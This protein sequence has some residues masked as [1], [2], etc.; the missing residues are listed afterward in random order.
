MKT[1]LLER[2]QTAPLVGDGA[3][4]TYLH[5]LGYDLREGAEKL[6]LTAPDVIRGVHAAYL[7]A[8]AELIETNTFSASRAVLGE[9]SD[10]VIAAAARL[11]VETA[12]GKAWVAGAV[13]P[14][15]LPEEE[16][17]ETLIADC[18]RRH[19]QTLCENGVDA[20][21]LETFDS[22]LDLLPAVREALAVAGKDIPVFANM[23]FDEGFA[24]SGEKAETIACR[25][26]GWG[27]A[28]VGVNCGRGVQTVTRTVDGL[29]AGCG[30]SA[31]VSAFP[32]AGYPER[33]GG[34]T[35]YLATPAYIAREAAG[36]VQK[37]VRIVGGCC[38]TTP[39]T[40]RAIRQAV[41]GIRNIPVSRVKVS[42]STRIVEVVQAET[43]VQADETRSGGFL[44]SIAGVKLPVIA[45]VDPPPHLDTSAMLTAAKELLK[46]G[47]QA[48]SLAE[49][50]LS[51]IRMENFYL[52]QLLRRETG[53]QVI[54]HITG[55]DRNSLGAQ[56]A[57]MAAHVAG[58]EAILAVTGD[59]PQLGGHRRA[60]S[61]YENN[62]VGLIRLLNRLN[63][64]RGLNG[65]D[66]KGRTNFSVGAAFNSAAVNLEAE[67]TRLFRKQEAG[68]R[69]VM[70]QPVFEYDTACRVLDAV[71]TVHDIRVFLGFMPPVTSR[72]A[73]HLHHEV[74]GIRLPDAFLEKIDAFSDPLDQERFAIDETRVL[75]DR[76]KDRLQGL[77]LIT[78]AYKWQVT[79][80][81]LER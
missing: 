41:G 9:E 47:V 66:L 77:Y 17:D 44:D 52:A 24:A 59:P 10:S 20:I 57:L 7:E 60:V 48:V 36:W 69:F 34:R 40:I 32:N 4:G 65:R 68:A 72:L 30:E 14:I 80:A 1:T 12:G 11:A 61:V 33:V 45:E 67:T 35:V 21:W 31:F 43:T 19:V 27:V 56:S 49:N 16:R 53:K 42:A 2:L 58:I 37:G 13:G 74:P 6:C 29:L 55:R 73:H 18:Y 38:G 23:V 26:T 76:L 3:T 46:A 62:S 5:E 22:W 71:Q 64:G 28:G 63:N 15:Y 54:C 51:S 25:L 50:P 78:P 75:I 81:L 39:E 79:A 8:G 70:T